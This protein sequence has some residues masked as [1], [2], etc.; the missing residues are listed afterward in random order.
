MRSTTDFGT[1]SKS[2]CGPEVYAA[3]NI[4]VECAYPRQKVLSC[5]PGALPS[6][7]RFEGSWLRMTVRVT[8]NFALP[9]NCV[10]FKSNSFPIGA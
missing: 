7:S 10:D 6:H 2:Q 8:K 9:A 5:P 1:A 3:R 4:L